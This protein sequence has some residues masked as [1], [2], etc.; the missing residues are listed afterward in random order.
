MN[1]SFN[2]AWKAIVV[3]GGS[4]GGCTH[5]TVYIVEQAIVLYIFFL[6]VDTI[7]KAVP[8]SSFTLDVIFSYWLRIAV[9]KWRKNEQI[10]PIM[11]LCHTE[12]I[13][14]CL[15]KATKRFG[16][17]FSSLVYWCWHVIFVLRL[18][19]LSSIFC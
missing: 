4:S 14:F 15:W 12:I 2:S 7:K 8:M 13:S 1:E 16:R 9:W 3:V 10:S 19:N 17:M 18:H 11:D 6:A 5:C